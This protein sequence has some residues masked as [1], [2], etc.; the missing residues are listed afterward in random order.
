MRFGRQLAG[1]LEPE[2]ADVGELAMSLVAAVGLS[3]L[4]VASG[5]VQNVVD[6]LEENAQLIGEA[7]VRNCLSSVQPSEHQHDPDA[8]RDQASRL[9]P[10]QTAERG[11]RVG[12][13][14]LRGG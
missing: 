1:P 11:A 5:D 6:D 7:A 2:Q 4:L 3:K 13:R 8:G 10:V 12:S 14:P 9:E